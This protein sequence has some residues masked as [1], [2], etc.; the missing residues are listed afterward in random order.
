MTT[1]T[2][3]STPTIT[4]EIAARYTRIVRGTGFI[5][6]PPEEHQHFADD[7]CACPHCTP[8]RNM[9]GHV[10]TGLWDTRAVDLATGE[11]RLVHYPELHMRPAQRAE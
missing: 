11:S 1:R 6:L 7:R 8:D 3:T 9:S 5:A 10:P 2:N 4:P